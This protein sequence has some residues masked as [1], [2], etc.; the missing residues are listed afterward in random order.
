MPEENGSHFMEGMIFGGL[1]GFGLG[2]LFAPHAGDKT[3]ELIREKLKELEMDEVVDKAV[4]YGRSLR[5]LLP[6][7]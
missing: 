6:P 3:R 4:E 2:I 5:R 1:I 7:D